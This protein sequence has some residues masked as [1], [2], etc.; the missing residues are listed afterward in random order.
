M[1]PISRLARIGLVSLGLVL[2]LSACE[3]RPPLRPEVAPKPEAPAA[4]SAKTAELAEQAGEFVIAAREYD[5]LA[6]QS[7]APQREL[8]LLKSVDAL[9]KAGQVREARTKLAGIDVTRLDPGIQARHR[10]LEAQLQA[11]EGKPDEALRLL[12]QAEQTPHLNPTLIADI[13]RV[14][15]DAE[16]ALDRPIDAMKSRIARDKVIVTTD[17]IVKNQQALWQILETLSR[18]R[19]EQELQASRDPVLAGWLELAIAAL[20]NAGNPSA[21]ANALERW[22]VSHA[23]HPASPDFLATLAQPRVG[24]IGRVQ[25]ITLL[26]PLTSDYAQAAAAVRDGFLSMQ[27][28]DRNPDKPQVTVVDI[29]KDPATAASAYQQAV[30]GGAEMVVGPLGLE[31]VDH[32][33]RATNLDVP[34]LLLSQTSGDFNPN[35]RAIFQFG[36]PPEQE[37]TQAA[38]RAWL[39][40]RRQAAV[41]YPDSAWGR[42]VEAAFVGAWQR[43]GG[44]VVSEQSYLLNQ[45]DY[46]DP[47]KRLLNITQSEARK[48]R[49][50]SVVRMKLK[51]DPRPREDIDFVFLAAESRAGRLIKPQLNYNRAG[52]L[53]VY[54][55]S[56]I[57]SGRGDAARDIDLDGVQFGDMPWMLVGD[58]RVAA[59]RAALQPAWPLAHTGLDRLFALGVDAYAVIPNLDRLAGDSAARFSGVTAGLSVGRSGRLHRQLLW[60][61]FRKGL[62]VLIDSFLPVKG[63]F[64][65]D[66]GDAPAPRPGG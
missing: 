42:R 5:L 41:L 39:D 27:I 2:A 12:G 22:R 30:Q 3:T 28:A 24:R 33:V 36:L 54:S 8:Y 25:R 7:E 34:T 19:L 45:A 52:R 14:R 62:P 26:L 16:L 44:I 65:I 58:G 60:A 13:Y 56:N 4:P 50:E 46:S 9:I 17:D 57:F 43:L 61:Q 53:P 29:G 63:L 32:L 31:A 35:N 20:E 18:T 23:G 10:I 64:D 21:L 37:A 66:T 15:A 1:N 6:R 47:V 11:L 40:G 55:T 59:L 48:D 51:F 38:E 49:L